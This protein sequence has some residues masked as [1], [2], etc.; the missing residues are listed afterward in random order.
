MLFAVVGAVVGVVASGSVAVLLVVVV[1]VCQISF[2]VIDC[3]LLL[4]VC[5]FVV[6]LVVVFFSL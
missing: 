4:V 3:W 1:V 5:Q 2:D 6:G